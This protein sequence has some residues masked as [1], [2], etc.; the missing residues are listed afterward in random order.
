MLNRTLAAAIVSLTLFSFSGCG[1]PP[2][3][4]PITVDEL[5]IEVKGSSREIA[6]TNKQAGFFYTETN[7][8]QRNSWQG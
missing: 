2:K 6:Y 3:N 8:I 7:A 5:A 1:N 4:R